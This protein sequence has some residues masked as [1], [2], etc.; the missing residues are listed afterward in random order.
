VPLLEAEGRHGAFEIEAAPAEKPPIGYF[1][2]RRSELFAPLAR[3]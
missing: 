2:H 3:E 1:A